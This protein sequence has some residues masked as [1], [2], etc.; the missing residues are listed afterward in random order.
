VRNKRLN[1]RINEDEDEDEYK[2]IG[3]YFNSTTCHA[4]SEYAR[5]VLLKKPIVAKYPNQSADDPLAEMIQLKNELSA[6][7]NNF[8]K[9]VHKRHTLDQIPE[10][11]TWIILDKSTQQSLLKKVEEINLKM[12][13]IYHQCLQK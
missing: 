13:Q 7:G 4:V 12:N 3:N 8:N 5:N 2:K 11:K 1:I 6:L 9:A 10:I